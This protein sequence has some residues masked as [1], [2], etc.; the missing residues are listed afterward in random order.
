MIP[1]LNSLM[2]IGTGFTLLAFGA[3]M[4]YGMI[5]MGIHADWDRA[6]NRE[7]ASYIFS[8]GMAVGIIIAGSVL[9]INPKIKNTR[10]W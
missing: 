5:K 1:K 8:C 9:T 7:I 4:A 3:M 10:I 2:R 6:A